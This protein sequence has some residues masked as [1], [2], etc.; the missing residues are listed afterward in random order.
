MEQ[1]EPDKE[2][3]L[4]WNQTEEKMCIQHRKPDMANDYIEIRLHLAKVRLKEQCTELATQN[5]LYLTTHSQGCH[6][7]LPIGALDSAIG[8]FSCMDREIIGQRLPIGRSIAI[9]AT[10]VALLA[11][12]IEKPA[13]TPPRSPHRMQMP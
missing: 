9:I 4:T 5:I 8:F 1:R 12:G 13:P 10:R 7:N 2:K 11:F 3:K 6:W